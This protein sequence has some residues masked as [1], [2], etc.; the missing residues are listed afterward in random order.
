MTPP[1]LQIRNIDINITH[2][3]PISAGHHFFPIDFCPA[4][5]QVRLTNLDI[6]YLGGHLH[7]LTRLAVENVLGLP[8]LSTLVAILQA[9][10]ALE[11]LDLGGPCK[12]VRE[13]IAHLEAM[14]T[15]L[16]VRLPGMK[17]MV[18]RSDPEFTKDFFSIVSTPPSTDVV[19]CLPVISLRGIQPAFICDALPDADRLSNLEGLGD[20]NGLC[21]RFHGKVPSIMGFRT[22]VGCRPLLSLM[23]VDTTYPPGRTP[24]PN[25]VSA[26][27]RAIHFLGISGRIT[28][29]ELMSDEE[30][31]GEEH[32]LD[33]SAVFRALPNLHALSLSMPSL[34][35]VLAALTC[36]DAGD[37]VVCAKLKEMQL[38]DVWFDDGLVIDLMDC[39]ERRQEMDAGP[40]RSLELCASKGLSVDH[41]GMLG[42]MVGRL[43][44]HT[45]V[46]R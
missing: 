34:G 5:Q 12:N 16:P 29:V 25:V 22:G 9:A 7:A 6:Q 33:L 41:E 14:D 30:E 32:K 45:K 39:L 44:C 31:N 24:H 20:I 17:R 11:S 19:I 37:E 36:T 1:M 38:L 10:P 18:L 40:L 4:V 43:V 2:P 42:A 3:F 8:D 46:S 28:S 15:D 27:V 23:I 26:I 35:S 21:L 13:S